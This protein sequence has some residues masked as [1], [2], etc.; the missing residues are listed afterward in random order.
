MLD[1]KGDTYF[2][3][4]QGK[5]LTSEKLLQMLDSFDKPIITDLKPG[6]QIEGT[7]CRIGSEYVFIDI[8]AISG[9]GI[10]A[11]SRGV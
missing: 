10:E 8:G 2:D 3:E 5:D 9:N 7:V 11:L 6:M 4:N 1:N